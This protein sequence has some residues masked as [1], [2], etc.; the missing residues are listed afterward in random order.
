ME[1][2]TNVKKFFRGWQA[3][4]IQ[5]KGL[6]VRGRGVPGASGPGNVGGSVIN[7]TTKTVAKH[8]RNG[9]VIGRREVLNKK[10]TTAFVNYVVD[11]LIAEVSAFGDFKFH[12]SGTGVAAESAADTALGTPTGV[13][14]ANGT[15][16]EG[17][18]TF[19]YKSVG[20]ITYDGTYNIT[21]H[22]LFNINAAG[23]LMDRTVIGAIGVILN[24]QIEFTF[25]IQFAAEA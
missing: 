10:V 12:D 17:A 19:E 15:Q 21:E 24:D 14:R 22:G 13:A 4:K 23:I 5:A 3:R 20:T 8:I 1:V 25:T 9:K 16:V 18:E 7:V 2:I 6:N 11:N